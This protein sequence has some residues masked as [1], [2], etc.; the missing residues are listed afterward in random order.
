MPNIYPLLLKIQTI[1]FNPYTKIQYNKDEGFHIHLLHL[2]RKLMPTSY[3]RPFVWLIRC[4]YIDQRASHP[5]KLIR[6]WPIVK[7]T[8]LNEFTLWSKV[9]ICVSTTL[10]WKLSQWVWYSHTMISKK[11][12]ASHHNSKSIDNSLYNML[13][14]K[15]IYSLHERENY[16]KK[17]FFI[18]FVSSLSSWLLSLGVYRYQQIQL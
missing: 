3:T 15:N 7:L 8:I 11:S 10:L 16:S 14:P 5:I 12:W 17:F 18:M 1:A 13:S 2:E 6:L 4:T 9:Q